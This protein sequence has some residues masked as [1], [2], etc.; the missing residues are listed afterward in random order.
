MGKVIRIGDMA[1]IR[2]I[3][4]CDDVKAFG[5]LV[6][7]MNPIHVND[8]AA[9]AAGFQAPVVYGMLAGSL[10][11][12]LL[13]TTLPGPQSVYI[14]QTLRFVAPVF[15]GDE[16]EARIEVTQFRKSGSMIAF[17]TT[18]SRIDPDSGSKVL[19]IDGTAIGINKT[20]TFEGESDW[21]IT[22]V[23]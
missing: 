11:S 1:C 20:V 9:R 19:C 8:E 5:S 18:V 4:S 21:T 10:F 16:V 13:G 7:D 3:I 15:V 17:R 14:S 6:G 22:S 12:G 2:R 23:A